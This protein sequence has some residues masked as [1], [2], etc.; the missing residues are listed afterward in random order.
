[1]PA[2][3]TTA[4]VWF[5]RDLR[6]HDYAPP[7][8]AQAHTHALG[9]FVIEPEWLNSPECD[10]SHVDFALGCLT[11][12]CTS[13]AL[14]GLPLLVRIG[15]MHQVLAELQSE[16][17]FTHLLSHEETGPG[18]SYTRDKHERACALARL[19]SR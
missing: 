5:K 6:L 10:A 8:A 1:M 16:V 4:L 12:L 13:L 3:P 17:L 2:Q 7:V 9:L 14:C 18:W 11:E 19:R 15:N